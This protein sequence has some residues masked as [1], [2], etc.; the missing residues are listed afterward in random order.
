MLSW[1]RS[2]PARGG[3]SVARV[4]HWIESYGPDTILLIGGSLYAQSDLCA[5]ARELIETM[6]K[7]SEQPV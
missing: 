3:V 6:E 2:I 4:P 5:A 1:C 7:S